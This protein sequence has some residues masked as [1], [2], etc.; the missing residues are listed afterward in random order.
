MNKLITFLVLIAC[1][2]SSCEAPQRAASQNHAFLYNKS[3]GHIHPQFNVYHLNETTSQLDF[4][5]DASELQYAKH[6]ADSVRRAYVRIAITLHAK[7]EGEDILDSASSVLTDVSVGNNDKF[8]H[9]EMKFKATYPNTY[10]LQVNITDLNRKTGYKNYLFIDKSN[11]YNE[12]NF[13]LMSDEGREYFGNVI[14]GK[15]RVQILT[16]D[17]S[18]KRFYVKYY[19]HRVHL[20]GPPFSTKYGPPSLNHKPD[21]VYSMPIPGGEGVTFPKQGLYFIQTD[22]SKTEGVTIYRFHE[23]YPDVTTADLLVNSLRYVSNKD[24]FDKLYNSTNKKEAADKY[25]LDLAGNEDRAKEL[26]SQ[27]YNRVQDANRYFTSYTE[28][29]RT[30]RGMVYLIFGPP[31]VVNKSANAETWIYSGKHYSS[32]LTFTFEHRNNRFTSNDFV[33]TRDPMYK[34]P[35]YK[36][37]EAWRQGKMYSE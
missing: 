37:V 4:L 19:K 22:S 27:Y 10:Y 24:E 30:D 13:M 5:I 9:G 25:W 3:A 12:Q 17:P 6:G 26:I 1:L 8:I 29:W 33:L 23:G 15:D 36:A 16:S 31:P 7:F 28:G 35:W 34:A 14:G 32:Y 11:H 2:A 20:P 18:V 21:S